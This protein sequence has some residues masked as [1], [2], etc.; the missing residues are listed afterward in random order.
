MATFNQLTPEQEAVMVGKQTEAPFNGKY[1]D[2]F[3]DGTY[4]CARCNNPLFNSEAKFKSGCGWPS[5]DDEIPGA[6]KHIPDADGMRTEIIC[7]NCDAHL[8]HIF[9]GEHL[10]Q[11][12][13]RL[14]VNSLSILFIPVEEE[15]NDKKC[16]FCRRLFLG[17]SI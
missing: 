10:T 11:K 14:C 12:D 16:N 6:T 9:K 8:G 5:F 7:A 4:V 2:F 1:D 13:T 3:E 15:K 17:H